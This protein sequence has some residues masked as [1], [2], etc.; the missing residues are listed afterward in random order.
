MKKETNV[1]EPY[2]NGDPAGLIPESE[3]KK[4]AGDNSGGTATVTVSSWLCGATVA[5]SIATCPTFKC[6]SKCNF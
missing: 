5:L 6:T 4:I 3:L 2:Y 1:L